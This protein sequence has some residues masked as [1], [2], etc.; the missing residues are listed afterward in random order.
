M[1]SGVKLF[2]C[3]KVFEVEEDSTIIGSS[4]GESSG[5]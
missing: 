2:E 5:K 1:E 3:V 4:N